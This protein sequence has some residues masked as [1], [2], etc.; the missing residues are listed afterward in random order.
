MPIPSTVIAIAAHP[1]DI[2]FYMAGTLLLLGKAG[3]ELHYLNVASGSCGSNQLSAARTRA[4]RKRESKQAAQILGAHFHGSLVDD[5]EIV[6]ELKTLRRLAALLREVNPGVVLTHSPQDYME[7]H[8]NTCR[9]AVS[10]AFSRGMPNF[11]TMPP[12]AA[13]ASEVALYHAM[14]H[15]LQD[16]LRNPVHPGAYVD[17]ASVH[18]VKRDALLA[19]QSQKDWLDASQG[20]GSYVEAMDEMSLKLGRMS[21]KFKHAEGWR[22]HLHYGFGR[23]NSDPLSE[24]LGRKMWGVQA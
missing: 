4:V 16:P 24:V 12:R 10:A 6:Y 5:L 17:T 2:E 11:R 1:D 21:G 14:P 22:Q 13:V 7:D 19:H 9:L 20:M 23:E 18:S 8:T 3:W 15:G